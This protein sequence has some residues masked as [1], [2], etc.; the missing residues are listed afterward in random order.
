M[1]YTAKSV[2]MM[3]PFLFSAWFLQKN[4]EKSLELG[5]RAESALHA[6]EVRM[7]RVL[8]DGVDA[9]RLVESCE[10]IGGIVCESNGDTV[11]MSFFPD[12]SREKPY[13]SRMW[14]VNGHN[15]NFIGLAE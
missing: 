3:I 2:L 10:G 8:S 6:A 15:L 13:E 12:E 4:H 1:N 5:K 9:R 11:T 7:A 14:R